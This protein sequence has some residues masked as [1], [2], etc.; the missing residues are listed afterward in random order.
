VNKPSHYD[1]SHRSTMAGQG[2]D[3]LSPAESSCHDAI[4]RRY[5]M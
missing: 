2:Q 4:H 1:A 5:D 3:C